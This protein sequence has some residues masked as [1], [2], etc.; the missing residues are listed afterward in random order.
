MLLTRVDFGLNFNRPANPSSPGLTG[1]SSIPEAAR[2]ESRSRGVLD[3]PHARVMTTENVGRSCSLKH[4]SAF[5][6]Q[7]CP[8]HKHFSPKREQGIPGARCTRGLACKTVRKGAHEHTGSAE[9]LRH[10][11]RNGLTAYAAL[12]P[13]TNS[14]CH[15]RCRLDG[16]PDPVGSKSP[17][18]AWHQQRVSGPHGFAVRSLPSSPIGFAGLWRRSSCAP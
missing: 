15:R 4:T 7:V 1:R 3:H 8:S 14:S 13:A 6:R 18:A 9:A 5:S 10:P 17:P 2:F 11:P 16:Y 12:T